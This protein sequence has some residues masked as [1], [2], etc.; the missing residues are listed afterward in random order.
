MGSWHMLLSQLLIANLHSAACCSPWEGQGR[1][2]PT[3]SQLTF[4]R[5][6]ANKTVF[7]EL[8]IIMLQEINSFPKP[9]CSVLNVVSQSFKGPRGL[10]FHIFGKTGTE[11]ELA[12]LAHRSAPAS[13]A[14]LDKERG[15]SAPLPSQATTWRDEVT[16]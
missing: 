7:T 9:W 10:K 16:P 11:P 14:H 5:S 15:V 2:L 1:P 8:F 13:C 6:P 3:L 12:I 4:Q